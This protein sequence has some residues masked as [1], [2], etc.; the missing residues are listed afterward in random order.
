M[1]SLSRSRILYL[2]FRDFKIEPILRNSDKGSEHA[3]DQAASFIGIRLSDYVSRRFQLMNMAKSCGGA[4]SAELTSLGH[5]DAAPLARGRVK[6]QDHVPDRT[7]EA[8]P[9][10]VGHSPTPAG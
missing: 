6:L 1:T 5:C 2:R 3:D 4:A 9:T 8:N 7:V 10:E